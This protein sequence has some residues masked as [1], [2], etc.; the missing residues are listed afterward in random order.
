MGGE[1]PAGVRGTTYRRSENPAGRARGNAALGRSQW[2]GM[3][4]LHARLTP[5]QRAG[6]TLSSRRRV[7]AAAVAQLAA[8]ALRPV[9][10]APG[11]APRRIGSPPRAGWAWVPSAGFTRKTKGGRSW[12][13]QLRSPRTFASVFR[14]RLGLREPKFCDVLR[15]L[16][17]ENR[18]NLLGALKGRQLPVFRIEVRLSPS[19]AL[20]PIH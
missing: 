5:R 9:E 10:P 1:S 13:A 19:K 6:P 16:L 12:P 4:R 20:L 3:Q 2:E 7:V 17:N 8:P 18:A 11:A 15:C 14:L